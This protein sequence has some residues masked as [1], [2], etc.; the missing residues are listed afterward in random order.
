M[1]LSESELQNLKNDLL[2]FVKRITRRG[3]ESPEETRVLPE[4]IKLLLTVPSSITN[5]DSIIE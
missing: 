1:K 4:I 2:Y 5:S 3:F